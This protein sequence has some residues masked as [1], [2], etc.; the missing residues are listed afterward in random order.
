MADSQ[1]S[2]EQSVGVK[3]VR[4]STN[5]T[6]EG[7]LKKAVICNNCGNKRLWLVRCESCGDTSALSLEE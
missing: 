4:A 6:E 2:F 3:V 5:V 7:Y 1:M